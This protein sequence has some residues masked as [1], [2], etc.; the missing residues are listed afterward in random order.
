MRAVILVDNNTKD[1]LRSEWGLAV[2]IEYEGHK[3]LLDTGA[4]DKFA[5]NAEDMG[6]DLAQVELAALSHAHY[7]HSNGMAA[8]FAR[9]AAA[10]F[11]LRKEAGENCYKTKWKYFHEYIGIQ[12]GTLKRFSQ[13]I[14]F[15]EGTV[16]VLP[17]VHLL[18][19]TTANL[20]EKGIKAQMQVR[21]GLRWK[22]DAFAHEQSLVFETDGG[23]VV[24]NSCSHAGGDNIIKEVAA[25]FPGR[26]IKALIGGLHL[27]KTDEENVRAFAGRVKATGIELVYTGHCTGEKP[28]NILMEELG[29]AVSPI[30]TGMEIEL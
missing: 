9:N 26:K 14:K 2:Y 30:Y 7:D 28:L 24:F 15:V 8:F 11:Y 1:T 16:E 23:L 22:P 27:F 18:P 12:K 5:K 6:I 21:Y 29:D 25:A 20:E 4:S 10:P 19:H 13:R 17:G 3:I